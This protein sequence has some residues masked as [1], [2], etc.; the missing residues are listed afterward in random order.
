MGIVDTIA[1]RAGEFA[2]RAGQ[3]AGEFAGEAGKT[4][5][6]LIATGTNA[7]R[8]SLIEKGGK[9]P[10]KDEPE[11]PTARAFS[12]M[13]AQSKLLDSPE[14]QSHLHPGT[15]MPFSYLKRLARLPI[16][17]TVINTA[18]DEIAE[19]CVPQATPHTY[20]FRFRHRDANKTPSPAMKKLFAEAEQVVMRGGGKY[21]TGGFEG[22]TRRLFRDSLY[23]DAAPFEP[24]MTKGNRPWGFRAIDARTVRR[25]VYD[26]EA[27]AEGRWGDDW[28]WVQVIDYE[29]VENWAPGE[30]HYGIRRPRTDVDAFGFGFAEIEEMHT[31]I[32]NCARAETYQ[33]I[34]F[35]T[36]IHSSVIIAIMSG[37]DETTFNA[38]RRGFESSFMSPS[39]KRRIPFVGL[40]AKHGED[41]KAVNLSNTAKD[42]EFQN[43]LYY[44]VKLVCSIFGVDPIVAGFHFGQEGQTN[45]LSTSSPA[46]RLEMSRARG[47]R[48]RL[49]SYQ[50][51]LN[52]GLISKIDEDIM[53]EFTGF[54][55]LSEEDKLELDIKTLKSFMTIDEIRVRHD[56]KKIGG[57]LGDLILDPYAF[58]AWS[59]TQGEDEGSEGSE[60]GEEDDATLMKNLFKDSNKGGNLEEL[61]QSL[62]TRFGKAIDRGLIKPP[63]NYKSGRKWGIV[64]SEDSPEPR[65]VLVAA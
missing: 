64:A 14:F 29:V 36:G 26:R 10:S 37:M 58:Q 18:I 41:I 47:T 27:L 44:N 5:G 65:V 40:S 49:R 4:I 22:E 56:L 54:D 15:G 17:A 25:A 28:R 23:Y 12:P 24:I 51:W 63:S 19:F 43:W 53:M 11:E 39:S 48:K 42:M 55:S 32:I 21:S 62:T 6:A 7:F 35:T 31:A 52:E 33:A 3:V 30:I 34:N 8:D 45:S 57:P 46:E 1:R 20:G 9:L 60:G 61:Q 38:W 2:G 16:P 59:M 50:N 13:E